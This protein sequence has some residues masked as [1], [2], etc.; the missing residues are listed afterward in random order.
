[1]SYPNYQ[2][3]KTAARNVYCSKK[4]KKSHDEGKEWVKNCMAHFAIQ[5]ADLKGTFESNNQPDNATIW[6]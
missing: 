6:P 1:M 3:L 4:K 5:A 2:C